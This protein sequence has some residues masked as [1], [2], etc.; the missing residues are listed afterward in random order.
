MALEATLREK[1]CAKCGKSYK[2]RSARQKYCSLLCKMGSKNCAQCGKEFIPKRHTEEKFCSLPCW[3]EWHKR[4][5]DKKC[6]IC[7]KV[8]H[9]KS[10][11]QK[12]CSYECADQIRRTAKRN[13]HC[14]HCGEP[15]KPNCQPKVRFCSRRCGLMN[16]DRVGQ[17]HGSEGS[18]QKHSNGYILLKKDRKWIMEHRAIMEQTL[19]RKLHPY[20]RVHHK[21]G[22]RDDNRPENLELWTVKKKDPPGVRVSDILP[23]CPTCACSK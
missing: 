22:V 3:Y 16:R 17:L 13:T 18:K 9:P 2:P 4:S 19:G 5:K 7:Q 12:T 15:L 1:E 6:P 21:N 10:S 23:H 8:F 14:A 11:G 20:E